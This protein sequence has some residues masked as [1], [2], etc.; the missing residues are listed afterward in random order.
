MTS[1][2]YRGIEIDSAHIDMAKNL[3]SVDELIDEL[4][5]LQANWNNLSLLGE[6]TNVGA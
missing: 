5:D 2:K 3:D 6:L 4:R 1:R